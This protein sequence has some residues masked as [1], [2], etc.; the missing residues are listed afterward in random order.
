M[1]R[2]AWSYLAIGLLLV[3]LFVFTQTLVIV[4]EGEAVVRTLFGRPDATLD[5]AGLYPRWPWPVHRV[6]RFDTRM[7]TLEGIF[8]QTLTRDGKNVIV[9]LYAGWRIEDPLRFLD[10]V[11]THPEAERNLNGLL[12]NYK[13]A[14]IGRVPFSGLVN[15]DPSALRLAAV[16]ETILEAARPE[17]AERYGIELAHVGIRKLS[18]PE[19]IT[20]Q[21]F[22]RMRAERAE[23][24]ERY[25]AEGEAEALRIRAEADSLRERR[26]SEADAQ[27]RMLRA[28]GDALAAESYRVFAEDPELAMFLR[29]LDVLEQ[30][31]GP[32]ATVVLSAETEPFD[33]LRAV[34]RAAGEPAPDA[35]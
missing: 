13:H 24:A 4:R 7:Q 30:V 15:T 14:A 34:P 5:R 32:N 8:E 9:L 31:L 27:A 16:E 1:N 21:V 18:L 25:R 12:S 33:L 29:K 22:E 2:R 11:G 6:Y 23:A 19:A 20:E 26:L 35:P 28:E 17:A 10:R 3:A